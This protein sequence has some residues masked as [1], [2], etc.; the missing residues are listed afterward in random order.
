[1]D[2]FDATKEEALEEH[3]LGLISPYISDEEK[4]LELSNKICDFFKQAIIHEMNNNR[5]NFMEL[6][7]RIK[8]LENE[9]KK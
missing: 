2:N 4:S 3:I 8:N 1:M 5:L 7:K 9:M 6:E